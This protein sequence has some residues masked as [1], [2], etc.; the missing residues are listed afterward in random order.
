MPLAALQSYEAVAILDG[1]ASAISIRPARVNGHPSSCIGPKSSRRSALRDV[2]FAGHSA[3]TLRV[4]GLPPRLGRQAD[5]SA[6]SGMPRRST[7][8]RSPR[9][10]AASR[11]R[12]QSS[13]VT[14]PI[15][16][17]PV[18]Q[19]VGAGI[20]PTARTPPV[21]AGQEGVPTSHRTAYL[22]R[23]RVPEG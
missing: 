14:L 23:Y 7:K 5:L 22:A 2:P 12:S 20:D 6:E 1:A 16:P 11:C 19:S 13:A 8:K 4:G 3:V 10:R 15:R 21:S 17:T 9:L 18:A